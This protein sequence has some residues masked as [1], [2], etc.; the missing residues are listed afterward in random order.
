AGAVTGAVTA[1]VTAGAI[2][3]A[4]GDFKPRDLASANVR[5]GGMSGHQDMKP[6]CPLLTE[7]GQARATDQQIV[8][9]WAQ[10]RRKR[11]Y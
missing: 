2:G 5:F 8:N 9:V 11:I 4:G 3:T 7:S 6:S 1:G 10:W